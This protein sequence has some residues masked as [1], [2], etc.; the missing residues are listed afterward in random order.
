MSLSPETILALAQVQG[1]TITP[2]RA[3]EIAAVIDATLAVVTKLPVAFEAEPAGFT[4]AL[5]EV[6]GR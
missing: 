2:A 5:E 1:V 4:T 6:A 3:P